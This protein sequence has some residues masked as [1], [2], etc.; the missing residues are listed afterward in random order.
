MDLITLESLAVEE[1][2][3]RGLDPAEP[4]STL[5]L[6]RLKFHPGVITRPPTF[7]ARFPSCTGTD[8]RTGL[9]YIGL[10]RTIPRDEV[11][12]YCGHELAHLILGVPHGKGAAIE[13]ACDYLGACLMAPRPAVHA[14]YRACGFDVSAIAKHVVATQTWA[15]LRLAEALLVPLAAV[16]PTVRVRGPEEWAW[17]DEGTIRGWARG[18]AGPGLRKVRVTDR[19][20][21]MLLAA[22]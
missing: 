19:P 18:K 16:G 7:A 15:G 14:L 10:K 4:V 11:Q 21:R 13:A 3:A 22:Y 9:R 8:P 1:Y 12:W 17:P 20:G 5:R 6:A 2:R